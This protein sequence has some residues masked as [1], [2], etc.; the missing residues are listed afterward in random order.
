MGTFPLNQRGETESRQLT[1]VAIEAG[2]YHRLT[3]SRCA[4]P[5]TYT[6][7]L[8]VSPGNEALLLWDDMTSV[9]SIRRSPLD[10]VYPGM[11]W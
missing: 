9:V 11:T 5:L 6:P 2:R 3:Q 1:L 4:P 10:L 7:Q 8:R